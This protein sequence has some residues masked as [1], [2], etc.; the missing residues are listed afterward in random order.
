MS[1]AAEVL[2]RK[3]FEVVTIRPD[4]TVL[5]AAREMNLRRIGAL[6]VVDDRGGDG[7][8][9]AGGVPGGLRQVVGM[10]TERDVLMRVVAAE[11]DP[12]TTRV[13][14]VMTPHVVYC[15]RRT[16]LG[17]LKQ[18]MRHRR[19]RHIPVLDDGRLVGMISIGDL[20]ALETESLMQTIT[21]LEEYITRG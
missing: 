7:G 19:I 21:V 2:R 16:P 13:A 11:R 20:N 3:G 6:V 8:A 1:T 12:R 15:S 4:S 14:E 10:F 18:L 5:E 17:E 9:G